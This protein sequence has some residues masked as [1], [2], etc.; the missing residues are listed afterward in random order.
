MAPGCHLGKTGTRVFR[1]EVN[2]IPVACHPDLTNLTGSAMIIRGAALPAW[3]RTYLS[4]S[5]AKR[6]LRL[7]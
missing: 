1:Q 2:A 3:H 7:M 5:P 4:K 6:T